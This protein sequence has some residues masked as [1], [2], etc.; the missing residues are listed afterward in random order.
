[1]ET[2]RILSILAVVAA[3]GAALGV[4]LLVGRAIGDD[5]RG[6]TT[7]AAP[8]EVDVAAAREL[9]GTADIEDPAEGTEAGADP[10]APEPVAAVDLPDDG[11]GVDG[12]GSGGLPAGPQWFPPSPWQV[13]DPPRFDD[14]ALRLRSV[15]ELDDEREV[16]DESELS[17]LLPPGEGEPP[18]RGPLL[19]GVADGD[20]EPGD[21]LPVDDVVPEGTLPG[22]DD[23]GPEADPE[24]IDDLDGF[25]PR[26]AGAGGLRLLDEAAVPRF[27]DLCAELDDAGLDDGGIECPEGHG[28]TVLLAIDGEPG[29]E[30]PVYSWSGGEEGTSRCSLSEELA[31]EERVLEVGLGRPADLQVT[32]YPVS[33]GRPVTRELRFLRVDADDDMRARHEAARAEDDFDPDSVFNTW[34]CLVLDAPLEGVWNVEIRATAEDGGTGHRRGPLASGDWHPDPEVRESRAQRGGRM[35]GALAEVEPVDDTRARLHLLDAEGDRGGRGVVAALPRGGHNATEMSCGQWEERHRGGDTSW[36]DRDQILTVR[37]ESSVGVV[38]PRNEVVERARSTAHGILR[39]RHGVT[40]ELCIVSHRRGSM[41]LTAPR[42]ARP[43]FE[44]VAA[45][46]VAD[47]VGHVSVTAIN[48]ARPETAWVSDLPAGRTVTADLGPAD[49]A[50]ERRRSS[51]QDEVPEVTRFVIRNGD[52]RQ[53]IDVMVPTPSR[54][55][56]ARGTPGRLELPTFDPLCTTVSPTRFLFVPIPGERRATGL[57]GTSF[58][59]DCDPPSR[60]D[61]A[62]RLLLRVTM[63]DHPSSREHTDAWASGPTL[64]Y[65]DPLPPEP[66][67]LPP[68][69]QVEQITWELADPSFSRRRQDP[70]GES[71]VVT[72]NFDRPMLGASFV[73]SPDVREVCQREADVLE[74][75]P[76]ERLR[77][78]I[79]HL[80]P[81]I[82]T[83][84]YPTE[85]I[86]AEGV[87][88]EVR[89]DRYP[90]TVWM[91]APPNQT[92]EQ[93]SVR[94]RRAGGAN[95]AVVVIGPRLTV[96][97]RSGT[98]AFRVGGP[99]GLLTS[100]GCNDLFG[101]SPGGGPRTAEGWWAMGS[102]GVLFEADRIFV[103]ERCDGV[104]DSNLLPGSFRF[105]TG[106][107]HGPGPGSTQ[108]NAVP[109]RVVHEVAGPDG[110]P[111]LDVEVTYT[112]WFAPVR[113]NDVWRLRPSPGPPD[114]YLELE[115]YYCGQ[116]EPLPCRPRS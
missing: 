90:Y 74:P 105:S 59:G 36:D 24:G 76:T 109:H 69:P 87:V 77:F 38:G 67:E 11:S 13:V 99:D 104:A 85:V 79:D 110:S 53:T 63:V 33:R 20:D 91:D 9:L 97:I 3:C 7:V 34:T 60:L 54:A 70:L 25:L 21:R 101:W 66:P 19:L 112:H 22:A 44:I 50:W 93:A 35:V 95:G 88:H 81:G 61:I 108:S 43:E 96:G 46:E 64:A 100:E 14:E 56:G 5:D 114:Q 58:G 27:V 8:M 72:Y 92:V 113:T 86:D 65:D 98:A 15:L 28:G 23:D 68:V 84:M 57:C 40:Y 16:P 52:T 82:V 83:W 32:W 10:D 45:E 48:W 73:T 6:A 78:R 39:P 12:A 37:S 55:C 2:R 102:M 80:C 17:E 42:L 89:G 115:A 51:S 26:L 75:E 62:G 71:V 29:S 1:M 106:T 47:P 18:P 111:L 107:P 4:G 30:V 49:R 94:V 31:P 103:P 116:W 41:V